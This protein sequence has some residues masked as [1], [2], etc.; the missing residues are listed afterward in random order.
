MPIF[1][2]LDLER[3]LIYQAFFLWKSA[4][5]HLIMLPFDVQASEKILHVIYYITKK[6]PK[7]EALLCKI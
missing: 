6:E 4:I 7:S 1:R 5:L 2:S 3:M